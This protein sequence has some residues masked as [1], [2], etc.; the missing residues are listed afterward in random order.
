MH[1]L[2]GANSAGACPGQGREADGGRIHQRQARGKLHLQPLLTRAALLVFK[3]AMLSFRL[4]LHEA[5]CSSWLTAQRGGKGH[6]S[7]QH[8]RN[9]KETEFRGINGKAER[10]K[11]KSGAERQPSARL[12]CLAYSCIFRGNE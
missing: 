3:P 1:K 2:Q 9:P 8:M 11:Q 12:E 6:G 7:L 4:T 5:R 10:L